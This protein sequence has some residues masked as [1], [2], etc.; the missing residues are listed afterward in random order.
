MKVFIAVDLED[1]SG[2]VQWDSTER[3]REREFIT[4]DANAAI[5]GAFDGG[6]TEVLVTEAHGNM[7]NIIPEE[8]DARARFLSGQPKPKNHMAGI[9][10]SFSGA[11]L[12]GYHSRAGTLNGVMAHTYTGSVFS[13][14]FNGLEVGEIGADAAI[15][16]HYGVPVILVTGDRAACLEARDLFGEVETT[17]VKEGMGRSSAICIQPSRAREQIQK[18]AERAVKSVIAHTNAKPFVIKSPV[19]TEV[20][21]TDPSYADCVAKIPS[22]ERTDGRTIA[23]SCEDVIGAFELFNAIQFLAGVVR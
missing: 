19:R 4:A 15:A 13:L 18:A 6:A 10:S 3:L 7:R 16:G 11:M 21:F 22:V 1:I 12:V 20:T 5:T 8:I 9:D 17:V 2:L 14:R 23:F